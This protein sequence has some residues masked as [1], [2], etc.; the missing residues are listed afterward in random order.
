MKHKEIILEGLD[1]LDTVLTNFPSKLQ[2]NSEELSAWG[3]LMFH[4]ILSAC[5]CLKF[6]HSSSVINFQLMMKR[7]SLLKKCLLSPAPS[8]RLR[9]KIDTFGFDLLHV[10]KTYGSK[11]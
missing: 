5:T 10:Y 3:C 9:T 8:T 2:C 7:K 11:K 4:E 1:I 6:I